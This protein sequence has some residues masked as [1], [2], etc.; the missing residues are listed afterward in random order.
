MESQGAGNGEVGLLSDIQV[1]VI[2]PITTA[3]ATSEDKVMECDGVG[4]Y[5][6]VHFGS[7]ERTRRHEEAE[8]P[9]VM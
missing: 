8:G 1:V 5:D 3:V 2:L 4:D 7:G 9:I 6:V